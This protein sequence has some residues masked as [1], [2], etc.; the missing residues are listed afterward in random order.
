MS[1]TTGAGSY[2]GSENVGSSNLL[3]RAVHDDL[4]GHRVRSRWRLALL[5]KGPAHLAGAPSHAQHR[6]ENNQLGVVQR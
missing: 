6:A 1:S 5:V 3:G 4:V 2:I